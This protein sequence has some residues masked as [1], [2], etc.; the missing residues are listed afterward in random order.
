MPLFFDSE[1]NAKKFYNIKDVYFENIKIED[2]TYEGGRGLFRLHAQDVTILYMSANNI[3]KRK[4][5][6][7]SYNIIKNLPFF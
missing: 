6:L 2:T 7:Q 1:L 5:F 4:N 3:G